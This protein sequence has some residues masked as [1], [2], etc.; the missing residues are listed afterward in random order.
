MRQKWIEH[1]RPGE[2]ALDDNKRYL[3][4]FI[5]KFGDLPVVCVSRQLIRDFRDMLKGCPRNPTK[6]IAKASLEEL[7][8]WA[9]KQNGCPLLAP[10]TI[11]AK[12]IGSISVLMEAAIREDIITANPCSKQFLPVDGAVLERLPYSIDD[13][14]KIFSSPVYTIDERWDAGCE[15]AQFWVPL[16]G[17]FA[18]ARLEEIGQLLI[19]DIRVEIGRVLVE[20]KLQQIEI[21]YFEFT[22]ID[23]EAEATGSKDHKK[24]LKTKNGRRKVPVHPFIFPVGE[25]RSQL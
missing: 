15:D 12:G 24:K 5:G 21:I 11:N 22:N 23:E 9:K 20:G 17:L 19:A 4:F 10:Q 3:N 18:G 16:I 14:N 13:L 1:A 2:K 7:V 25:A 8:E 6:N